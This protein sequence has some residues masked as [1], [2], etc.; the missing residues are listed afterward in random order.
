VGRQSVRDG[1]V[2]HHAVKDGWVS[3]QGV[4]DR[5]RPVQGIS[6]F[7]SKVSSAGQCSLEHPLTPLNGASFLGAFDLAGPAAIRYQ[8]RH[9]F[10][11]PVVR[12]EYISE[13]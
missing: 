12:P 8:S 4:K 6:A 5:R 7:H 13:G 11:P 2:G 9:Y 10:F 3:H 1:W